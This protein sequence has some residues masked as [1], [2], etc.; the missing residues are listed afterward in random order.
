MNK[1][2]QKWVI[3]LPPLVLICC[4]LFNKVLFDDYLFQSGDSLSPKA[5]RL[6]IENSTD[7]FGEYPLWMPWVFSGMPS[8]H[9]FQNISDYYI[10]HLFTKFLMFWKQKRNRPIRFS[11]YA[12]RESQYYRFTSISRFRIAIKKR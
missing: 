1:N 8:V 12:N 6:G 9:S 3:L 11:I 10:P 5:V 2:I 7:E 4:I